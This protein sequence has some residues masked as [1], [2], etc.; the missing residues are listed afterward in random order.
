MRGKNFVFQ[1]F[2]CA[3]CP[4]GTF[5]NKTADNCV[6]CPIGKYQDEDGS[7]D[8]KQCPEGTSTVKNG[9]TNSS[10]C[11]E[12][13]PEG[14]Y[15]KTGLSPCFK[16]LQGQYQENNQSTSCEKCQHTQTTSTTG[17]TNHSDCTDFDIL[18]KNS[19][20]DLGITSAPNFTVSFWVYN[21]NA[22][23][24][25][26][27]DLTS[28]SQ[29]VLH[30]IFSNTTSFVING[31]AIDVS[32]IVKQTRW[33]HVAIQVNTVTGS[34]FVYL[35]GNSI[36]TNI[37]TSI[38]GVKE[39]SL[40]VSD[41]LMSGYDVFSTILS[42]VDVLSL[43]KTCL[44]NLK[45]SNTIQ[46]LDDL[47]DI[48]GAKLVIPSTCNVKY[49]CDD[50]PCNGHTCLDIANGFVCHCN[51]GYSGTTCNYPPDY[52]VNNNCNN[53]A[54]CVG[55]N[56]TYSCICKAGYKGSFCETD[57]VNGN[58]NSWQQWS[59]CSKSCDIGIRSRNRSCD[60]PPPD[61]E[62]SY[63]VG[64]NTQT[65]SCNTDAC[66]RCPSFLT[67][68][69]Y[70]NTLKCNQVNGYDVCNVTC[71]T[72]LVF[73]NENYHV[74]HC[75]KNTSFEW[76]KKP[77]SCMEPNSPAIMAVRASSSI[78][79]FPCSRKDLAE[80]TYKSNINTLWCRQ[81]GNCKLEMSLDGCNYNNRRKRSSMSSI[82]IYVTFSVDLG[83]STLEFS[84]PFRKRDS[85]S[86]TNKLH[87]CL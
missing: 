72:G 25:Q 57:V 73:P 49:G 80:S 62:G 60:N 87:Q 15:S 83:K 11:L 7:L 12:I 74:Y 82:N 86:S 33:I 16:C 26:T 79:E 27:L 19:T 44:S 61:D 39:M 40:F 8:C 3:S 38:V 22:N 29:Y 50:N 14:S 2:S 36:F 75:G 21:R 52:C 10:L 84:R 59:E 48:P 41:F 65:Q 31:T 32:A 54:T 45:S 20:I 28:V 13:C 30:I 5:F 64:N 66:Q 70:G 63:C 42:E 67:M 47:K 58:W 17:S 9:T 23:Q 71:R 77:P 1:T 51:N 18:L 43:S 35:N 53:G 69:N 68:L 37:I 76:Q 46:S 55:Q 56:G 6:K 81:N 78:T 85:F 34:L 24:V 4:T